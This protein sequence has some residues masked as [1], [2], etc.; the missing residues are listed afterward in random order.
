M[1]AGVGPTRAHHLATAAARSASALEWL[2]RAWLGAA[3]CAMGTLLV[4]LA[5]V[6][7]MCRRGSPA[8]REMARQLA[9]LA[10]DYGVAPP[11][12]V[13][14]DD[15]ATPFVAG[16]ASPVIVL[17]RSVVAAFSRAKLELVL[18]SRR[19][20]ACPNRPRSASPT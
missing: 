2:G 4:R 19:T 13:L 11:R 20:P 9:D 17:P 16:V 15:A 1:N 5:R 6:R 3:A 12:L 8:P 10:R 18:R 14:S 7:R